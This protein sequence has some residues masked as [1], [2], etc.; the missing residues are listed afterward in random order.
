MLAALSLLWGIAFVGIKQSLRELSPTTLTILRFAIADVL[1]LGVMLVA[2][3][4]RPRFSRADA[5]RLAVIGVCGVPGYHL[6]LNWGERRTGASIASLIIASAPVM[7]ALLS[8]AVLHER[9]SARRWLAI[10]LAF[11][12]VAILALR[13]GGDTGRASIGG[14]LVTAIAAAAWAVY[15]IVAKPLTGRASPVQVTAAGMFIGSAMLLPL[16]RGQTVREIGGLSVENWGWML[17]LG[18]GSSVLGYFIFVWALE[19][20]G[21]TRV[22][23]SLYSVPVVALLASWLILD[24]KLGPSIFL[25]GAMVIAGIA[26]AQQEKRTPVPLPPPEEPVVAPSTREI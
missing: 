6:A 8:I 25:A 21:A 1:L 22:A 5:W 17:L 3:A 19:R 16:V 20:L 13:S 26:L 23:V 2:P 4:T 14:V 9:A 11:G 15:T 10:A 24:E 7:V 18:A 12:G